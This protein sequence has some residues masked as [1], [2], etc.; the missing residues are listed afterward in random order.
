MWKYV[1]KHFC[2]SLKR[3]SLTKYEPVG[4]FYTKFYPKM[5]KNIENRKK[6]SVLPEV[7]KACFHYTNFHDTAA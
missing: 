2:D 7:K 6:F 4:N 5:T 3:M 1:E